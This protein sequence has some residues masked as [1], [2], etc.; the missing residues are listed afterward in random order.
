MA[1]ESERKDE[2]D[3]ESEKLKNSPEYRRF[4]Q[5]LRQVVKAPPMKSQVPKTPN[6]TET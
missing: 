4:K 2:K 6:L 3:A 5:L 1:E